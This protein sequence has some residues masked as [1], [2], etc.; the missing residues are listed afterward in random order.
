MAATEVQ[1]PPPPRTGRQGPRSRVDGNTLAPRIVSVPH[2]PKEV[3][4]YVSA[5]LLCALRRGIP[6]L[7][8][9]TLRGSV[10]EARQPSA[11]TRGG[12]RRREWM[13]AVAGG[14]GTA[15]AV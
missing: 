4:P 9:V 14:R 6:V 15:V 12:G 8:V 3:L 2:L 11:L 10:S 1:D 5:D 13:G 7:G